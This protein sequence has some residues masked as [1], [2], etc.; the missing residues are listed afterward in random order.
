M[1][2]LLRLLVNKR[3]IHSSGAHCT[4]DDQAFVRKLKEHLKKEY[5]LA[6]EPWRGIRLPPEYIQSD[7]MAPPALFFGIGFN[8]TAE[9]VLSLAQRLN[10]PEPTVC[11]KNHPMYLDMVLL[12]IK[13][14]ISKKLGKSPWH[15]EFLGILS[16][17]TNLTQVMSLTDN[18]L[19]RLSGKRPRVDDISRFRSIRWNSLE[20]TAKAIQELTG[21]EPMWYIGDHMQNEDWDSR[22]GYSVFGM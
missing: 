10:T 7:F 19:T 12:S 17:N 14:T 20:D 21:R 4:E 6:H 11:G 3:N 1:D 8:Q 9:D 5:L 15:I 13:D 18:S 16:P 22:K 2:V